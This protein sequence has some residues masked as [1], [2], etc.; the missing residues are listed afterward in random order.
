MWGCWGPCLK[1][2]SRGPEKGGGGSK[3][4]QLPTKRDYS[5]NNDKKVGL[6][7]G[8]VRNHGLVP[9]GGSASPLPPRP[10]RRETGSPGRPLLRRAG[11]AVF[12]NKVYR[13]GMYIYKNIPVYGDTYIQRQTKRTSG[14][15]LEESP[16]PFPRRH[17]PLH[18]QDTHGPLTG[19]VA[20]L[21]LSQNRFKGLNQ[22]APG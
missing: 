14:D 2:G 1:A 10:R 15:S 12:L 18:R 13:H 6:K 22:G 4:L 7:R 21:P 19:A 5:K 16:L 11:L 17:P 3:T 8:N 9:G 20:P